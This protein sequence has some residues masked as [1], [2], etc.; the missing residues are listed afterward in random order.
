MAVGRIAEIAPRGG[1]VRLTLDTG[2]MDLSGAQVGDSIA[3]SGVCLTAVALQP[4]RFVA[5]VSLETLARTTLGRL[6]AGASVNLEPALRVGDRLGGHL[7]SGHVDGVGNV[8]GIRAAARSQHMT[9]SAPAG[10]AR[11]IAEKGSICIDG[12]SLTVN[13]VTGNEFTVNVVPHTLA[14]TTLGT[15]VAG[16]AVNIEVDLLARYVERLMQGEQAATPGITTAFLT[17]H[18]FLK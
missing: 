4:A 8:N 3:V 10:L 13:G 6:S 16:R 12:V 9:F 5:D 18:G 17:E 1:D 15:Y 11:Y 14:A 7:V 2:A